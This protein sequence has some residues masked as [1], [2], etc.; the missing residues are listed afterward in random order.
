MASSEAS[1]DRLED[2]ESTIGDDIS[3]VD[4]REW[5][6]FVVDQLDGESTVQ[7]DMTEDA[8]AATAQPSTTP[9]PPDEHT[10][11]HDRLG[12]IRMSVVYPLTS[13]LVYFYFEKGM[14]LWMRNSRSMLRA[15]QNRLQHLCRNMSCNNAEYVACILFFY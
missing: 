5:R 6:E 4:Q 15:V 2:T 14:P 3:L 13:Q 9:K 7:I 10:N 11:V 1:W 12:D 8:G